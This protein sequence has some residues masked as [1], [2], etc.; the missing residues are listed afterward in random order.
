MKQHTRNRPSWWEK[1]SNDQPQPK[2]LKTSNSVLKILVE[3]SQKVNISWAGPFQLYKPSRLGGSK[4]VGLKACVYSGSI[5]HPW[6]SQT[7]KTYIVESWSLRSLD[8]MLTVLQET[9]AATS[10]QRGIWSQEKF[11]TSNERGTSAWRLVRLPTGRGRLVLI[12]WE[13][14]WAETLL[15]RNH[16]GETGNPYFVGDLKSVSTKVKRISY[17]ALVRSLHSAT[18]VQR[19][20]RAAQAQGQGLVIL[21]KNQAQE[22]M[23]LGRQCRADKSS[24]RCKIKVGSHLSKVPW[25][26]SYRFFLAFWAT[27]GHWEHFLKKWPSPS[28]S[29]ASKPRQEQLQ[30]T[31]QDLKTQLV[32]I[33]VFEDIETLEAFLVSPVSTVK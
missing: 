23:Y 17:Q 26:I 29:S 19:S 24:G 10:C 7:W 28:T 25:G 21:A 18:Q 31:L 30:R 22:L 2:D 12:W 15:W 13:S 6:S 11:G 1:R 8:V 9:W 20:R 4:P 14:G 27:Q 5:G 33:F 16:I 3:A 32:N